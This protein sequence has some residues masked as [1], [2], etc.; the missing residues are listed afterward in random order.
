[1]IAA[2]EAAPAERHRTTIQQHVR[3][4]VLTVLGVPAGH[5]LD[6]EQGLR[7]AGLDS[8]MALEL[9]NRLQHSTARTLPATLAFDYPTIAAL[10][11]YLFDV[12]ARPA[13]AVP[14][15]TEEPTA[16]SDLESLSEEEAAALLAEE[17]AALRNGRAASPGY[18]RG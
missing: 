15:A 5:P 11:D 3:R 7:D 18:P 10:T 4:D 14:A 9:K 6:D 2:L 13:A 8:L 12:L 17:I 16:A 1:L